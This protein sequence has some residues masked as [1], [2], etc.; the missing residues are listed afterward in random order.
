MQVEIR[1]IVIRKITFYLATAFIAGCSAPPQ[2][3]ST[4]PDP[5][6]VSIDQVLGSAS[7]SSAPPHSVSADAKAI[8]ALMGGERITIR[9]YVGDASNILSRV[10]KVRGMNFKINGPEPHLPLLVTVDV[11]S[12]SF[13]DFL[14][15]VG[16][17]FGQRAD[18]VLGDNRVEI[19][20]RGMP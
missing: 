14:A 4:T 17:Q 20:Y 11:D 8:P 2:V 5:V 12:V 19:R 1:I 7:I 3:A 13:E 10:A 15:Q 9:S 16:F 18:L 6:R